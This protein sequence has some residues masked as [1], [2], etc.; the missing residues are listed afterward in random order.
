MPRVHRKWAVQELTD[1]EFSGTKFSPVR[2]PLRVQF[3]EPGYHA[4]KQHGVQARSTYTASVP[5][6][7]N[8][9]FSPTTTFPGMLVYKSRWFATLSHS[10]PKLARSHYVHLLS[11]LMT[12]T[13]L[14]HILSHFTMRR[15]C[16]KRRNVGGISLSKWLLSL[17]R[18]NIHIII[19]LYRNPQER[20][21]NEKGCYQ[22]MSAVRK[23]SLM[24]PWRIVVI[25]APTTCLSGPCSRMLVFD[26]KTKCRARTSED[27][28]WT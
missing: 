2:A 6:R 11:R 23:W 8:S 12:G 26:Y 10:T 7:P 13:D 1:T 14:I 4:A 25:T 5:T 21:Q 24:M 20:N 27:I 3:A 28:E 9:L 16:Q 19:C 22:T 17:L 15:G 18:A